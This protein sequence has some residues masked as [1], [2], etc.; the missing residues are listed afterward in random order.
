MLLGQHLDGT[1]SVITDITPIVDSVYI[2]DWDEWVY[3]TVGYDTTL[4]K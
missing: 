3:N 4:Q 1:D 2:E